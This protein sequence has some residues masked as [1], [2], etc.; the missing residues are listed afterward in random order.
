M[1][2]STR[3]VIVPLCFASLITGIVSS[4]GTPWGLFRY[5]WVVLKLALAIVATIVLL[6]QTQPIRYVATVA[7]ERPLE[8][9]D[10][11]AV[12]KQLL[13]D[14]AAALVVLIV[15]T[16]LAVYKPCGLTKY[17]YRKQREERAAQ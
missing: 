1:E 16:T 9:S 3:F 15:N 14:A 12:R 13:A 2:V 8:R 10:L 11:R 4:L 5:Y 17:G 7:A 6:V